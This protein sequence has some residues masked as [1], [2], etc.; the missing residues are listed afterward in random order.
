MVYYPVYRWGEVISFKV[1]RELKKK[2]EKLDW[3]SELRAFVEDRV[4]AAERSLVVRRILERS[5]EK[6]LP[7]GSVVK[8]IREDREVPA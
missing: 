2:A 7:A 5:P 8:A 3:P 1:P 6:T 4:R